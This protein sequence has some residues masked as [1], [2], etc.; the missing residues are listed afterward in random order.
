MDYQI[1]NP[2]RSTL[3]GMMPS[4][5]E[6]R[7]Q[8]WQTGDHVIEVINRRNGAASYNLIIGID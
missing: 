1:F 8:L 7:G 5:R 3:L 4:D 2:D 6:Y